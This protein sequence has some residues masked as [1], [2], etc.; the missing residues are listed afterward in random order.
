MKTGILCCAEAGIITAMGGDT[1]EGCVGGPGKPAVISL[2]C[3]TTTKKITV[4]SYALISCHASFFSVYCPR[5][6]HP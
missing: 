4:L 1:G 3:A 6:S 2:T 5:P